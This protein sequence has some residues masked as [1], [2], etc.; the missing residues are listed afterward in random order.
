MQGGNDD[1]LGRAQLG[2][3]NKDF[4]T[5]SSGRAGCSMQHEVINEEVNDHNEEVN[6]HDTFHEP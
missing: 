2:L 3:L 6:D 4:S 1:S 5:V